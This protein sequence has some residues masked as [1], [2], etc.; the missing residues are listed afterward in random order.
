MYNFCGTEADFFSVKRHVYLYKDAHLHTCEHA[1]LH[2]KI[3]L[4]TSQGPSDMYNIDA[5]TSFREVPTVIL[6]TYKPN[7]KYFF[8]LF[9]LQFSSVCVVYI[10]M[11]V[12]YP[13]ADIC[14]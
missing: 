12:L 11:C 8:I 4:R 14:M 5:I 1:V 2:R 9:F 13:W 10:Y 6:P 7:S 3:H